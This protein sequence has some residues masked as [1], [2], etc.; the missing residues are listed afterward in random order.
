MKSGFYWLIES[1]AYEAPM[2]TPL[3]LRAGTFELAQQHG[4][5]TIAPFDAYCTQ[6]RERAQVMA[7]AC[8]ILYPLV[9]PHSWQPREHG[10]H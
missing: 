2:T 5:F 8:N 6:D 10:F 4:P 7:D 1:V 3:Y 9:A